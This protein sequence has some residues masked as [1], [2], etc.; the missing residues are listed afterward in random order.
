ME[1]L[2]MP[3]TLM[4]LSPFTCLPHLPHCRHFLDIAK[5]TRSCLVARQVMSLP[6]SPTQNLTFDILLHPQPQLA[7]CLTNFNRSTTLF[8]RA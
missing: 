5:I 4:L 7:H 3:K 6:I 2:H 1:V 8:N